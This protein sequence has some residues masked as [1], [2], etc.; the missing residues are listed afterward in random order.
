MGLTLGAELDDRAR[1]RVRGEPTRQLGAVRPF[2]GVPRGWPVGR[3]PV[4]VPSGTLAV[5]VRCVAML[6][7]LTLPGLVVLLTILGVLEIVWSKRRHPAKH[8]TAM[9]STGFDILQE[10]LYPSKKHEIEQR[11]HESLMAEEDA[12]GAPPRSRIDLDSGTAHIHLP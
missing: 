10:A 12:E 9:A 11:E 3:L 8:G 2:R 5:E 7:G 1:Q 4:G 6:I